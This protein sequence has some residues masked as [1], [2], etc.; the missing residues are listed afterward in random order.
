MFKKIYVLPF[1]A[2]GLIL[3]SCETDFSLNG[4]YEIT[5]V[6][7]GLLDHNDD[8]HIIKITKAF[9]GDGNNYEYAQNPDSNYFTSVDAKVIEYKNNQKTGKEWQLHDS[10]ISG[11]DANGVFYA[12]DQKV[13][14]FYTSELDSTAEYELEADLNEGAHKISA[15]TA[16]IQNFSVTYSLYFPTYKINFAANTVNG[17]D[18]YKNWI[19]VVTEGYHGS[20]Y[21]YRYTMNW[22]EY[23]A[24]NSTQNF[25]ATRNNGDKF[26]LDPEKPLTQNAAFSGLD[27]YNWVQGVVPDDPNVVQRKMTGIDLKISVAHADLDQYLDVA[28]PVSGIAQ[29][30]PEYTNIEGG[31]G[32][33]SSRAI[34]EIKNI[35]LDK[36]STRELCKGQYT[37]S[38]GFCSSA[39]EDV[40]EPYYC[41]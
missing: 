34:L 18:D 32:L 17:V 10:I 30:Q 4:E 1:F 8:V 23:Y 21:N 24:D 29:V 22:T 35:K 3:T 2:L 31:L 9:L 19:F 6:V 15:R 7:F 37:I 12:P 16:M 26:Q 39:P 38:K 20:R 40:A 41:P 36:P 14:V 11:K 27:F 33:F 25:S 28:Q 13:Y 5:P